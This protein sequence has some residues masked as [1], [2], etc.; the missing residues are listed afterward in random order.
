MYMYR[1]LELLSFYAWRL[2]DVRQDFP[3]VAA[4]LSAASWPLVWREL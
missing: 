4:A 2:K 1:E 3:A